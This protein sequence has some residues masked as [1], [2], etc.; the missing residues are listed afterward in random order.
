PTMPLDPEDIEKGRQIFRPGDLAERLNAENPENLEAAHANLAE[1]RGRQT[2]EARE[3]LADRIAAN[4]A[5]GLHRNAPSIEETPVDT[6]T[7]PPPPPGSLQ[8][9]TT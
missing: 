3:R 5:H 8:I 2:E 4:E 7:P 6:E 1:A 9:D